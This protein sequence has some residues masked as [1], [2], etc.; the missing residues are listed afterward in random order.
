MT[1]DLARLVDDAACECVGWAGLR[2]P[3]HARVFAALLRGFRGRSEVTLLV[4]PSLVRSAERPPDLVVIDPAS[5][6]HVIEVKGVSLEQIERV[7]GGEIRLRYP[8]RTRAKNPINQVRAAMFDIKHNVERILQAEVEVPFL[9]WVVFPAIERQAFSQRFELELPELLFAEDV[10][11]DRLAKRLAGKGRDW[12]ERRGRDSLSPDELR[13]VRRAFGDS[14]VLEEAARPGVGGREGSLGDLFHEIARR[15]RTLSE[16]QQRL[17]AGDWRGGP[18]LIRGVAGSG[19]TVVL[20]AHL[21]RRLA[22]N[23]PEQ[24]RLFGEGGDRPERYLAVCFNRTLVPFIRHKIE[25]AYHQR[26]GADLPEG[27]V[28]VTH[29]NQLLYRLGQKSLWK[30]RPVSENGDDPV[31]ERAAG[32]LRDLEY[33]RE[34]SPELVSRFL[35]DAV[36]VDEAQDLHPDEIRLMSRL[37][38]PPAEGELAEIYLFYDDAQ[39]LYGRPRPTWE[40]LGVKLKGRSH[41]MVECHR[42]TRQIVEPAFN[43]LL[44][45]TAPEGVR[46]QTRQFADTN[47][48]EKDRNVLDRDGELWRTRFAA[49]EGPW[50]ELHLAEDAGAESLALLRRLRWLIED[51]DVAPEDILVLGLRR[52]RLRQLAA[53]L[54]GNLAVRGFRL[55]FESEQKDEPISRPGC[56]TLSTVNSAKGYD[57]FCVLLVSAN[58]F[59]AGREHRAAFYVA[60]TRAREHLDVFAYED[61]GLAA[62]FRLAL[63]R[64]H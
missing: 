53:R 50:P 59:G 9:W 33:T 43:V 26:K 54:E 13:A 15:D 51:E 4:E 22:H 24:G 55:P 20:A 28:E 39:N 45:A 25:A 38:R 5:G 61:I 32:Y 41:V 58:E 35:Y 56:L 42:N 6:V 29:F 63:D 27:W 21:A 47:Y 12:L 31:A 19:K 2:D 3:G 48:L 44:G 46:V 10:D 11:Q 57:A 40:Q 17:A 34:T 14:A 36:Y 49:R 37:C 62:E 16:E 8:G 52:D 60:C 64:L 30:Y 1:E 23:V 7:V 18:R